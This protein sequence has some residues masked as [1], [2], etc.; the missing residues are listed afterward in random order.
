M[1]ALLDLSAKSAIQYDKEIH[2]YFIKR[3]EA[4]KSIKS[5][6]NVV[7]N[8][9]IYRMFAVIKRQTPYQEHRTGA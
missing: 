5:T 6:R 3:I 7:R 9:I 8:K 1:K 2:Q 4:G